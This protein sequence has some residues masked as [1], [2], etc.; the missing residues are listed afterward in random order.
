MSRTT[1]SGPS[2]SAAGPCRSGPPKKR[3]E[4]SPKGIRSTAGPVPVGR[5]HCQ[6]L[7]LTLAALPGSPRRS[8]LPPVVCGLRRTRE[9]SPVPPVCRVL[10][11]DGEPQMRALRPSGC[12][13]DPGLRRVQARGLRIFDSPGALALR[14]RGEGDRARPQVPRVHGR[15][16]PARRA[17][18]GGGGRR[19]GR[20]RRGG[21]GT[22]AQ[23]EAQEAR[24]QPGR[25]AGEGGRR[26]DKHPRFGYTSS[27]AEHPGSGRAIG[28]GE[29]PERG[30]RVLGRRPRG[31]GSSS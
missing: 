13:R 4:A 3:P 8:F 25:A 6:R 31:A 30:R 5:A 17:A 2:C 7:P 12:V 22:V 28:R 18:A 14:G 16:R 21:A 1:A 23:G 27:R 24:L 19:P 26:P 29:A 10:A 11:V 20:I 9:R 15:R